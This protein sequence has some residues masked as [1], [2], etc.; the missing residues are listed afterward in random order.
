MSKASCVPFWVKSCHSFGWL[1]WPQ[2]SCDLLWFKNQPVTSLSP[3]GWGACWAPLIP[4]P[5][6][7]PGLLKRCGGSH[8]GKTSITARLSV[9][10]R[11]RF[12]WTWKRCR[13]GLWDGTRLLPQAHRRGGGGSPRGVGADSQRRWSMSVSRVKAK[14]DVTGETSVPSPVRSL[15]F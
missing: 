7:L 14:D 15:S 12:S 2:A 4:P 13:E 11:V 8:F 5:S 10:L 6:R 1:G 9:S 3:A